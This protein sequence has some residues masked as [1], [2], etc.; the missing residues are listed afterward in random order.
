[1]AGT[2]RAASHWASVVQAF[3]VHSYGSLRVEI[4][5]KFPPST[6]VAHKRPGNALSQSGTGSSQLSIWSGQAAHWPALHVSAT[7]QQRPAHSSKHALQR[8]P[9]QNC[10][11]AQHFLPHFLVGALHFFFFF[12]ATTSCPAARPTPPETPA[13][14]VFTTAR[15]PAGMPS[16][17]IKASNRRSTT[18]RAPLRRWSKVIDFATEASQVYTM[19]ASVRRAI[20]PIE[21]NK[22]RLTATPALRR[23]ARQ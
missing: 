7:A 14:R 21:G 3:A 8:P 15:R 2:P 6:E 5:Q 12:F 11:A 10:P 1:M 16:A 23:M 9:V 22:T 19:D 18:Q 4:A 20:S 13:A 17:R